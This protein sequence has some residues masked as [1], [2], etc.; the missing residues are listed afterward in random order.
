MRVGLA[1]LVLSIMLHIMETAYTINYFDCNNPKK[2]SAYQKTEACSRNTNQS[3]TPVTYS[4]LQ[5]KLTS[6]LT[7]FSCTITRST[8]TQYCGAYSHSKLAQPPEVEIPE[9]GSKEECNKLLN[10]GTFHTMDGQ[11]HHVQLNTEN[12]YHSFDLGTITAQDSGIACQDQTYRIVGQL[13]NEII[14]VS[15]YKV[16]AQEEEFLVDGPWVEAISDRT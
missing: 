2:V 8:L 3:T 15:Q 13:I 6:K 10:Q 4:L 16:L 1:A 9:P 5:S 7:G 14:R 12:I 11:V